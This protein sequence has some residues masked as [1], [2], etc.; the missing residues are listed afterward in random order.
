MIYH[1]RNVN[2]FVCPCRQP[3][4]PSDQSVLCAPCAYTY[5]ATN[6]AIRPRPTLRL[7]LFSHPLL[8][9]LHNGFPF[10]PSA[11]SCLL[12]KPSSR[13]YPSNAR[14]TP[15]GLYFFGAR[16]RY[17]PCHCRHAQGDTL[18]CLSLE[19]IPPHRAMSGPLPR[20]F[21]FSILFDSFISP[22]AQ[23]G[24]R[25]PHVVHGYRLWR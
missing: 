4:L 8:R 3:K 1:R 15:Q 12:Y 22:F 16:S 10:P 19:A 18:P 11:Q 25:S 21:P 6:L 5:N 20:L 17:T 13:A 23:R 2:L 24:F 7:L 14:T 9:P